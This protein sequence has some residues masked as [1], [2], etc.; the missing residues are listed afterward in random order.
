MEHDQT[1]PAP[2]MSVRDSP[3]PDETNPFFTTETSD[4]ESFARAMLEAQ[5]DI[6]TP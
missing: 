2:H 5:T 4:T 6:E 3:D 1:Q